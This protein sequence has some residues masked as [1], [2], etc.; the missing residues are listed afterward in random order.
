MPFTL[1]GVV[2]WGRTFNEY[3]GMFALTADDTTGRILGGGDGPASFNAEAAARNIPV[4][5]CDP[6]YLHPPEAIEARVQATYSVVMEQIYQN[7]H[8]F[9]W[10][11]F[12]TPERLGSIRM[13]AM[14]RFL[15]DFERGKAEGRYIAALLPDLPFRDGAFRLA[16]CSHFLFLYSQQFSLEFH[17]AAIRE[18]CRVAG[19]ARIFP[20]H[21]LANEPSPLVEPITSMLQA[22][23]YEVEQVR[24]LYEFQKGAN[25]ML[26]VARE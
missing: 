3:A 1:D 18:M 5:S 21:N 13:N 24:V 11:D 4:V 17:A 15:T 25:R 22:E 8:T 19:E 26:R 16:V 7:V 9:V 20:L 10:D 23:G 2:P 14:R 6:I 12:Q